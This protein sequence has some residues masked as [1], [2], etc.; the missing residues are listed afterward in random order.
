MP[1][2]KR[3]FQ[4]GK[5]LSI[6]SLDGDA[7]GLV[8]D[9][10]TFSKDGSSKDKSYDESWLQRLLHLHPQALPVAEL[11]PGIGT[12]IPVGREIPTPAGPIDNL[13]IT[14]EGNIV[15]VEC[16]LWRNPEARRRV[17]S[18]IIDYAQSISQWSYQDLDTAVRN[19]IDG[20][21]RTVG[22]SLVEGIGAAIGDAEELDEPRFIDAVQRNLR[23]GRMLLLVVGDGIRED[24]ESLADFLQM[25]AGFH[26]TL[27]LIEMAVFALPGAG[28][29]VQP[30]VLVRTLNIERA[31]VTLADSSLSAAP[32]ATPAQSQPPARRMSMTEEVFFE[33]L[34]AVAPEAATALRQFLGRAEE[35]GVY[36]DVATKSALLKWES[37]HGT[38]FSLGGI[39]LNGNLVSYSI[40][41]KPNDIGRIDLAHDYMAKL[42][43]LGGG[44]VRKTK[45]PT[46]WYVVKSGT[47]V[48][49]A[50]DVLR[51]PD[52]WLDIIRHYQARLNEAE[53]DD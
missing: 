26:F 21:G 36:L 8:L 28:F 46:Q 7:V 29:I 30:R 2:H 35:L 24:T 16:K 38:V 14:L 6:A 4:Y 27:G 9:R 43:E 53:S 34:D 41:W 1:N 12:L 48:A 17:I 39:D 51:K 3:R 10:L 20:D 31:I 23:M 22:R 13:F 44:S 19:G 42:A 45:D 49:R 25:H 15:L 33:R 32:V 11:E 40:T 47:A 50:I 18:Q 37:V 52:E 5:P